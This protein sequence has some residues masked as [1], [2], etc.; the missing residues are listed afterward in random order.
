M[1]GCIFSAAIG[2]LVLE[3]QII[4][5][6][7]TDYM[8]IIQYAV[9]VLSVSMCPFTNSLIELYLIMMIV[10]IIGIFMTILLILI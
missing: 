1:H 10:T 9:L 5:I 2:A 4:S 3:H 8:P 7:S 6:H